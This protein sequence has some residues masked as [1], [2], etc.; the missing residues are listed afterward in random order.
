[1]M[2]EVALALA[3]SLVAS[4]NNMLKGFSQ[5]QSFPPEAASEV[6]FEEASVEVEQ[7]LVALEAHAPESSL[8][9]SPSACGSARSDR[10]QKYLHE[11]HGPRPQRFHCVHPMCSLNVQ[12]LEPAL[13]NVILM[14]FTI[15]NISPLP[16]PSSD[17]SWL[18]K[19]LRRLLQRCQFFSQPSF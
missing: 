4:E 2:A 18:Q 5:S 10:S 3:A 19:Q 9:G 15:S 12:A 1:M 16:L 11:Q 8:A 17:Q 6:A 7:V 14:R 13:Q